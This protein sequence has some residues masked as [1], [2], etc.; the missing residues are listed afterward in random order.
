MR[1][2]GKSAV[3]T[4]AA[5]GI[6]RESALLFAAEGAAVAA[7]DLDEDGIAAVVSDITAGGGIAIPVV[8][9][10]SNDSD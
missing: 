8:A 9:D 7:V 4:G 2:E 6:G 1:L 5:S 10:V 3:I